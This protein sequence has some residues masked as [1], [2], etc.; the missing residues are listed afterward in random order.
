MRAGPWNPRRRSVLIGMAAAAVEG[1]LGTRFA[2]EAEAATFPVFDALND[3]RKPDLSRLGL[4]PMTAIAAI[5]RPGISK[6]GVDTAGLVQALGRLPPGTSTVYLDIESWPLIGVSAAV[7][8]Q[9]VNNYLRTAE[10]VRRELP[11]LLFGFYGIAPACVYWPILN[12]NT[13]QLA[14]WHSVNRDLAPLSQWVSFVL[15]SLYTFYD[16]PAGWSRFAITTIEEARQ[17][18]RPVFPFLWNQY[19]DGNPVLRGQHIK[20]SDWESELMVCRQHADGVVLWSAPDEE[21]DEGAMWWQPVLR[22]LGD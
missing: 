21:W 16:D 12:Q 2:P 15:P 4:T 19:F 5:W 7:A 3:R 18:G 22:L 17:Y 6:Q 11:G 10:I 1:L 20:E 13:Q 14:E 8:A 9:S